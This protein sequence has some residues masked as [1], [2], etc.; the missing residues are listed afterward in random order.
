MTTVAVTTEVPS[1]SPTS[2]MPSSSPTSFPTTEAPSTSPTSSIPSSSPTS[3][4]TTETPSLSPSSSM[5]SSSPTPFPTTEM[6]SM[7]PTGSTPSSSPTSFPTTE[8]PSAK[9][10]ASP[11]SSP[12]TIPTTEEPTLNPSSTISSALP[13]PQLQNQN[14]DDAKVKMEIRF[15]G[16]HSGI[17]TEAKLAIKQELSDVTGVS[18]ER[19][20]LIFTMLSSNR[21]VLAGIQTV[22][23]IVEAIFT[24]DYLETAE[25]LKSSIENL[26]GD[27]FAESIAE[28]VSAAT[29]VLVN[30]DPDFM[31]TVEQA[32]SA[33]GASS[34]ESR[35]HPSKLLFAAVG[36]GLVFAF[37][38]L[39]YYLFPKKVSST[40]DEE[41]GEAKRIP[42][43]RSVRLGT[44]IISKT[45]DSSYSSHTYWEPCVKLT[46]GNGTGDK[47]ALNWMKNLPSFQSEVSSDLGLYIKRDAEGRRHTGIAE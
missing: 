31:L 1:T 40:P 11:S 19:I 43:D 13:T 42:S 47:L 12:S 44:R 27:D 38:A 28:T 18:Q 30:V 35:L 6:P 21:R 26:V 5:P 10:T 22:E 4:P 23:S 34:S 15:Y 8:V 32:D 36:L 7:S 41:E 33:Q 2:S 37:C 17:W 25:D 39:C 29:N 46:S 16:L 45:E 3:F 9:P 24:T 14:A 20:S